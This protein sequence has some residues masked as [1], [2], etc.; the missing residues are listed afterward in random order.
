MKIEFDASLISSTIELNPPASFRLIARSA[1]EIARFVCD[2][3]TTIENE[4]LRSKGVAMYALSV[5]VYYASTGN[6][7]IQLG[8]DRP[9]GAQ[10][11]S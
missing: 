1:L 5:T 3:A 7:L 2:R 4:K 9:K 6:Q 8:R 10:R 11:S